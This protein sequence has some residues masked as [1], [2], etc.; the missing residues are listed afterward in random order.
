MREIAHDLM[1]SAVMNCVLPGVIVGQRGLARTLAFIIGGAFPISP[2]RSRLTSSEHEVVLVGGASRRILLEEVLQRIGDH[3]EPA[4]EF[5][6][7]RLQGGNVHS[8]IVKAVEKLARRGEQVGNGTFEVRVEM[9]GVLA[10]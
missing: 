8:E 6:K 4:L 10:N 1:H 3:L 7:R 5:G 9:E 2:D